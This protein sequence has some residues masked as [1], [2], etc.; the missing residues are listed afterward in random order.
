MVPRTAIIYEDGAPVIYRYAL[1]KDE[2]DADDESDEEDE[3]QGDDSNWWS[4]LFGGGDEEVSADADKEDEE[5]QRFH[6]ADRVAVELGLLDHDLAQV[7]SGLENGDRIIV[8]G[9][10]HLRDGARVRDVEEPVPE[11]DEKDDEANSKPSSDKG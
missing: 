10:S 8:V 2:E 4:S 5:D 11:K 6:V 7:M 9:Q 1:P 3:D